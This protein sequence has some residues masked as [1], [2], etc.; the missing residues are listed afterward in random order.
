MKQLGYWIAYAAFFVS[1]GVFS[2]RPRLHLMAD[3]EA[4]VSISFSHAAQ[5]V[6]ECSDGPSF[7]RISRKQGP[8]PKRRRLS[9]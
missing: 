6:G 2:V 8:L 9:R 7:R 1:L 3:D 5:R 4:I